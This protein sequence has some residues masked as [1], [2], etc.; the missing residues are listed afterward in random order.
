MRMGAQFIAPAWGEA[1]G[2]RNELRPYRRSRTS[3]VLSTFI[4]ACLQP[5]F[6]LFIPMLLLHRPWSNKNSDALFRSA[7]IAMMFHIVQ[8]VFQDIHTV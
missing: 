3:V 5:V 7:R 4:I 6:F 2:G 1:V 8:I